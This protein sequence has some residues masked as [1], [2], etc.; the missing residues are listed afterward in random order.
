ML[1]AAARPAS[2]A[3]RALKPARAFSISAA[4]RS[5]EKHIEPALFPPGSK[6]G[7]V[8]TDEIHATGLERLQVL[9][10]LTGVKVFDY[11]PLD[12]SRIGTK[13]N[14]VKV[15]SWEPERIIGCT[16]APA[17]SHELHWMTLKHDTHPRCP[18]CGSVYAMDFQGDLEASK[19]AHH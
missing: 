9:G 1:R 11:D 5:D 13:S 19:H 3:A 2:V 14:P 16:G 10:E 7:V 8:P 15:F 18:E 6:A 17:E 4:R 12:S